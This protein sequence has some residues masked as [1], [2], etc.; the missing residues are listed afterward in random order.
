MP[1]MQH[2]NLDLMFLI[3]DLYERKIPRVLGELAKLQGG[4]M[5]TL[6]DQERRAVRFIKILH[7]RQKIG[8]YQIGDTELK[9]LRDVTAW[10]M[11]KMHEI[12]KRK[13]I[14]KCHN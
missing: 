9:T 5:P 6:S 8:N 2:L 7:Q 12:K 3:G 4:V 13:T 14:S 11:A 10:A 1:S